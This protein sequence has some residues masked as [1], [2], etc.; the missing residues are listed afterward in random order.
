MLNG[1]LIRIYVLTDVEIGYVYS[2]L[3]Y[4]NNLLIKKPLKLGLP[5]NSRITLTLVKKILINI[6]NV[7]GYLIEAT[8][9]VCHLLMS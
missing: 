3:P 5:V 4:Y 2:L 1:I 6:S 9:Q 8:L 7:E